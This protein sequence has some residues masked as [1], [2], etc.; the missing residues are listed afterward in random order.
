MNEAEE[1]SRLELSTISVFTD[2]IIGKV[3]DLKEKE[4]GWGRL[5]EEL[6]EIKMHVNAALSL[7]LINR[8]YSSS[9]F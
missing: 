8:L 5:E 2:H 1:L 9:P 6:K 4:D 3:A 7:D